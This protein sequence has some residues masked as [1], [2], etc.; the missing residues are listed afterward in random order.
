[1]SNA[2]PPSQ[3]AIGRALG[4]SSGNM[5]KLRKLGCPMDSVESVR[6]WRLERQDIA[7]RKPEPRRVT[8]PAAGQ[9]CAQ[10]AHATD[11]MALAANV[12][13]AGNTI[14]PLVPSL[15]A[16]LAAVPH[17]GRDAVGLY[18]GVMREL[19]AHVLALFPPC[20][21][22]PRNDD[23]TPV[24]LGGVDL[25]DDDARELGEFWYQVAAGEFIVGSVAA[26]ATPTGG[27][28]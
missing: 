8:V 16:A 15:R 2:K 27:V 4:L 20:E 11:L 6:A 17:Q 1:M 13:E 5:T 24:Y 23:G 21:T 25:S 18:V 3:N 7:R 22:D 12:L 19:V 10:A 26:L 9:R 28:V 14:A